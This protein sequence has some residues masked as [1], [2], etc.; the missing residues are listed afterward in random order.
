M[1]SRVT[2]R[3]RYFRFIK[4]EMTQ[5]DLADRAGCTRQ[6][7]IALEKEKYIPSLLLALKIAQ[8]LD[9]SVEDVFELVEDN[10]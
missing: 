9:K 5:A 6:T 7:I 1:G 4:N 8:A 10:R 2:N 3:I